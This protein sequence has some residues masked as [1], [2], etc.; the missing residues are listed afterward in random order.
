VLEVDLTRQRAAR[1][2]QPGPAPQRPSEP[3]KPEITQRPQPAQAAPD[4]A[5]WEEF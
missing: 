1:A 4:D 5:E 2:P 3:R